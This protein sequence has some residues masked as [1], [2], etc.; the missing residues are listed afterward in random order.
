[1]KAVIVEDEALASRHLQQILVEVDGITVIASLESI[2]ETIE[3]FRN[4]PLPDLAF[5]DIQL[6]D[7]LSFEIFSHVKIGC[8]VI[9]TTAYDQYAL[10]AFKVNSIDYLLKPIEAADVRNALQKLKDLSNQTEMERAISRLVNTFRN[11]SRYKTHFLVPSKGDKL[12]PVQAADIACFYID[13]G[14]VKAITYDDRT[15]YFDHTLEELAEMLDPDDFFRA[16]RQ[17]IL[18]RRSI[19]DIDL[20]FNNRLSVNLVVRVPEKILVSKARIS[21]FKEWFGA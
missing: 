2:S 10:K 19:K 5:M 17:F 7:G 15:F 6:A 13:A 3:W 8:P 1:M 14:T 21:V 11:A 9:F 4:N 18:A 12:I 16:N 20:W